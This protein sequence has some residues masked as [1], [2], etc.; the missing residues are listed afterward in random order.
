M[1]GKD[2]KPQVVVSKALMERTLNAIEH[3]DTFFGKDVSDQRHFV[4]PVTTE[5]DTNLIFGGRYFRTDEGELTV[6]DSYT[7]RVEKCVVYNQALDENEIAEI[8]SGLKTQ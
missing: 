5:I 1:V 3:D 8:L 4:S 7:G 2:A 6:L